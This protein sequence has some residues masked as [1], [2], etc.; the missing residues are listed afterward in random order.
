MAWLCFAFLLVLPTREL[1]R[2]DHGVVGD[3]C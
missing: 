1:W 2:H 3:S